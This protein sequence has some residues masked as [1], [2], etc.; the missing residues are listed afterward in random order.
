MQRPAIMPLVDFLL[1]LMSLLQSEVGQQHGERIQLM[2]VFL[3]AGEVCLGKLH[4]RQLA[5]ANALTQLTDG[6]VQHIFA[7]RHQS[8]LPSELSMSVNLSTVAG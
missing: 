1:S 2:A 3:A 7:D 4:G 5:G 6:Q 8:R